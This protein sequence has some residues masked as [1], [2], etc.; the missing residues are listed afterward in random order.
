M[1][2]ARVGVECVDHTWSLCSSIIYPKSP[3][4]FVSVIVLSSIYCFFSVATHVQ[5]QLAGKYNNKALIDSLNKWV[6][7]SDHSRHERA[8]YF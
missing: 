4:P 2:A 3:L 1:G 5:R 7:I 6:L 8:S